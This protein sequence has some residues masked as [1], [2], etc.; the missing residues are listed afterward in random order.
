MAQ[1]FNFYEPV[2]N[3]P[4]TGIL[5]FDIQT[6]FW[7]SGS[8][9]LV[10]TFREP[11][12]L[13]SVLFPSFL[14]VHF[15]LENSKLFYI[16][17]SIIFGLTKSELAVIF[18]LLLFF[19]EIVFRKVNSKTLLFSF[20]FLLCFFIPVKECDISPKNLECPQYASEDKQIIDVINESEDT[21]TNPVINVEINDYLM[22]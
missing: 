14:L 5:G 11:I 8:H 15:N 22:H 7:I 4:G 9:R 19:I 6:N 13:I 17:S 18:V 3:R 20:V 10:G 21:N 12:F 1:L 2:R 16:F